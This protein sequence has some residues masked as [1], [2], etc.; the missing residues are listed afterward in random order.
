EKVSE[1]M[2][3]IS[4]DENTSCTDKDICATLKSSAKKKQLSITP[5][6][7][8]LLFGRPPLLPAPKKTF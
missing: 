1:Q 6:T 2:P 7:N 8:M 3:N 4:K 5:R